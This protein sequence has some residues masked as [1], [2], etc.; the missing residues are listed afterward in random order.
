[1][2]VAMLLRD[3]QLYG[4]LSFRRFT[5]PCLSV[6]LPCRII[7]SE[8]S[9]FLA[10]A[11]IGSN[12]RRMTITP[13][14][15]VNI[16][17][18][19]HGRLRR[20]ERRISKGDLQAA[21]RHGKMEIIQSIN[22]RWGEVQKY[23]FAD[24]V[25]I[26]NGH[27]EITSWPVPGF[28]LD[29]EQVEITAKMKEEHDEACKKIASC[30]SAWTSHTVIIVDQ[31]GSMRKDDVSEGIT[32]SDAMWLSL[33]I[34]FVANRLETCTA[35]SLDVVSVVSMQGQ[36]AKILIESHPT[37]WVLFNKFINFLRFSEPGLDGNYIPALN[38]A[39]ELLKRN[40]YGSCALSLMFISDGKPSDRVKFNSV[41]KDLVKGLGSQPRIS[42]A[43][44]F[45]NIGS[46]SSEIV[47]SLASAFGRRLS[48]GTVGIAGDGE[49]FSVLQSM[50]K[51]CS[52]FGV[53]GTFNAVGLDAT[54]LSV[55]VSNLASTLTSTQM[56]MTTMGSSTQRCVR[57]VLRE[58]INTPDD[59]VFSDQSWNLHKVEKQVRWSQLEQNIH[60]QNPRSWDWVP[61][62]PLEQNRQ[63][64]V[65]K[66]YFG[67][68]AERIVRKFREVNA[69]NEFV[70]NVMV[71]K[72]S[73]FVLPEDGTESRN[74]HKMF[75]QSQTQARG[76]AKKFNQQLQ[77]I[78][79][80]NNSVPRISFLDCTVYVLD[81]KV[82]ILVEKKLQTDKFAK[83]NSNDGLVAKS[84][85]SNLE[86][87]SQHNSAVVSEDLGAPI[88][89]NVDDIPQVTETIT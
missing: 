53:Q 55:V 3:S 43:A 52:K 41:S 67:E 30:P 57:E 20:A 5:H 77:R 10:V 23:T 33:A 86:I 62:R 79:G 80:I 49:D 84:E 40:D 28:G 7:S 59:I 85:Q 50:A 58:P 51:T 69:R 73:R 88:E 87:K 19:E 4:G 37:N 72:E 48:V 29:V 12:L 18:S 8:S 47:S 26:A 16:L 70:G 6:C 17:S 42:R 14:S 89:F 31:S 64:A 44:H 71:A 78:P 81:N 68:G 45:D 36:Q 32:R 39:K 34:N 63:I 60:S 15:L 9:P 38:Q 76:L 13:S 66:E 75:C 22:P 65:R 82:E 61:E 25:Y 11:A 24:M 1:M 54:E 35:S 27:Q 21:M 74:F 83:W 56:E 46:V 2:S